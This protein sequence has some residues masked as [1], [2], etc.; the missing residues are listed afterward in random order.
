MGSLRPTQLIFLLL[1]VATVAA[2]CGFV[3]STVLRQ[4]KR[5]AR[6]YILLGFSLGFIA[7]IMHSRRRVLHN[8]AAVA[9][10]LPRRVLTLAASRGQSASW[11]MNSSA[12][13]IAGRW[14]R[15]R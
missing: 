1:A 9:G 10:Q 15:I 3:A 4:N 11:P 13:L 7:G 12:A 14:R 2:V 8:L 5:R 6:R